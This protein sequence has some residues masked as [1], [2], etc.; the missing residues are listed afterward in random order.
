MGV[1]SPSDIWTGDYLVENGLISL[2]QLDEASDLAEAW[3]TSLSDVLMSRRW[4]RPIDYYRSL[5]DRF[6]IDFVDL[7]AE[8]P[9]PAVMS[10]DEA[11][12]YARELTL[13]WKRRNGRLVVATARPGPEAVLYARSRWGRDIDV[14]LTAKFD[15]LWSLQRIFGDRH[16]QRAVH[17]L[18][19]LDPEM[20]ARKQGKRRSAR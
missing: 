1:L 7:H 3:D 20:S 18:A 15:I 10:E 6:G 2:N 9:D 14:V 13:P 11:E 4:V 16:S 17:E 12:R 19:E 5:A 8:P